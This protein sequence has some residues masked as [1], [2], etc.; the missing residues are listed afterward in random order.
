MAELAAR[1]GGGA[2]PEAG[3]APAAETPASDD[4]A[5]LRELKKLRR[6]AS[7]DGVPTLQSE[8]RHPPQ[9]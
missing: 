8:I 3:P 9:P 6:A 7:K 4:K 5:M 2:R 1:R